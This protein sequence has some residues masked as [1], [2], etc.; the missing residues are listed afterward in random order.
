MAQY[1]G[2]IHLRTPRNAEISASNHSCQQ[3]KLVE[4]GYTGVGAREQRSHLKQG[5][6]EDPTDTATKVLQ[7]PWFA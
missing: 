3:P 5:T 7:G 1:Q 6:E 2:T 4:V